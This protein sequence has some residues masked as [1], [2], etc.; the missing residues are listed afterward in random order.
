MTEPPPGRSLSA[1]GLTAPHGLHC[2]AGGVHHVK[3]ADLL[4]AQR[5]LAAGDI[6]GFEVRC[7]KCN[8]MVELRSLRVLT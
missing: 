1:L 6:P 7:E 2:P 4:T 8:R 3:E 5:Y